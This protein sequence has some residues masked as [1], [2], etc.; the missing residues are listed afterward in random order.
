MRVDALSGGLRIQGVE[1]SEQKPLAQQIIDFLQKADDGLG[2]RNEAIDCFKVARRQAL[3]AGQERDL[4]VR[5]GILHAHRGH[6]T[7]HFWHVVVE[8]HQVHRMRREN[9]HRFF[10][11]VAVRTRYP[12]SSSIFWPSARG[13]IDTEDY[14]FPTHGEHSKTCS[15]WVAAHCG[16]AVRGG[17]SL[18][19][20]VGFQCFFRERRPAAGMPF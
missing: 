9:L 7:I 20:K 4:N 2:L 10:A 3:I 13:V 16:G 17:V 18:A 15:A 6:A 19:S 5:F 11:V 8:E 14:W 12:F 1:R